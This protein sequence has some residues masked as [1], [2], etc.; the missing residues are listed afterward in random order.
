MRVATRLGLALALAAIGLD[1]AVFP[2]GVAKA[3]VPQLLQSTA[4]I[5][6][7]DEA[8]VR[9]LVPEQSGLTFVGCPNC[10][11][12]QMENQLVWSPEAPD[13][14]SCQY[15]KHRYPSTRYPM[16]HVLT[17]RNPRGEEQTYPYWANENGYR[18]FF[19]AR[20]DLA[21]QNYLANRANELARLYVVTGDSA[22]AR[23]AAVIL[24][25]FAEVIPGWC[26]HFDY[27][28]QQKVIYNGG[29][30]P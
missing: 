8:S 26:Y 9:R 15:C 11:N 5:R 13:E 27:P 10:S 19:A 20:R 3:E 16:T 12:G 7:L 4:M 14:V 17:V 6:S 2:A 22:Y 24:E 23:R 28:Y 25:R 29:S 18:Y 21:I 1:A 30:S